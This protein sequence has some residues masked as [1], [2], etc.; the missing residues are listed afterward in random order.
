[1]DFLGDIYMRKLL[2]QKTE[3]VLTSLQAGVVCI[4]TLIFIRESYAYVILQRKT[5]RLRKE[6]GNQQ[7]RSALDTG[8]DPAELFKFSIVRPIKMLVLSPIVLL[9][10]LYQAIGKLRYPLQG[11]KLISGE[12]MATYICF[13]QLFLASSKASTVSRKGASD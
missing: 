5:T 1:M 8:R 3:T 12:C 11:V 4:V 10:S 7:L 2:L 9:M 6:T 13:S